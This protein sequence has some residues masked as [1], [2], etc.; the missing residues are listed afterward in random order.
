MIFGGVAVAILLVVGIVALSG[1]GGS[2]DE[3]KSS[4][5]GEQFDP[6]EVSLETTDEPGADPYTDSVATDPTTATT[7]TPAST[8]SGTGT[9]T[10]LPTTTTA[11]QIPPATGEGVRTYR[12]GQPGLYGGTRD[13]HSCDPEKMIQFLEANPTKEAAWAKVEGIDASEVPGYI[14]H[15]TP[16]TLRTDTWVLNHGYANGHATE[17]AAVLQAGTAVLVDQY[18]VP[19]AKCFC[20]NP[21]LPPVRPES[22]PHYR[23][24]KWPTFD[25][26]TVV[27]IN[28][29]V[30]VINEFILVDPYG[31]AFG[32]KPGATGKD[33]P[34][35]P[36]RGG[37]TT[38]TESSTTTTTKPASGGAD[39]MSAHYVVDSGGN[40]GTADWNAPVVVS[41]IGGVTTTGSG[42]A[43]VDGKCINTGDG[44]VKSTWHASLSYQFKVEGIRDGDPP[45]F[46]LA[47][48]K[49]GANLDS[50]VYSN[51]SAPEV[52]DCRQQAQND[53]QT[54]VDHLLAGDIKIKDEPG[55]TAPIGASDLPGT[56]TL[57]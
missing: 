8:T 30:T 13:F 11:F 16:V 45:F 14:R 54:F 10:T 29:S 46:N 57:A 3:K 12:G 56:V 27:I 42:K 5:T 1:G 33:G 50:L 35:K 15:L 40:T 34:V 18:G 47:L 44:E 20:G 7:T 9:T 38:T 24:E 23:G 31:H 28:Q 52:A 39:S 2:D 43:E 49:T 53:Y 17:H 32:R 6:T 41:D 51:P 22:P 19:R 48:T 26:K 55:A 4:E 25:P 21:L 36:K 37:S